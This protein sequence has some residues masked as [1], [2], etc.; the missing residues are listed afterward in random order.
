[1]KNDL[2]QILNELYQIDSSFKKYENELKI[3]IKNILAT[4]PNT[5]FDAS[6]A[7]KLRAELIDKATEIKT[8]NQF[9]VIDLIINSLTMRKLNY[10]AVGAVIAIVIMI[11]VA[12]TLNKSKG[13]FTQT[14][15]TGLQISKVT[16]SAFGS[17]AGGS[18][19]LGSTDG[20]GAAQPRTQSGGGG[21]M[22]TSEVGNLIP[23][24][25]EAINYKYVYKGEPI[26]LDQQTL[27]VLKKVKGNTSA[28]SLT[29]LLQS[30][31]LG[32]ADLSGFSN[33][34]VQN[35]S[36]SQNKPYGYTINANLDEGA[37]T[38][39]KNHKQWPQV[40][41]NDQKCYDQQ[42]I[43]INDLPADD[44]IIKI[45]SDFL[46]AAKISLANYGQPF[47]DNNWKIFY[48]QA[49]DKASFY[50]PDTLMVTYPLEIN[51]QGVFEGNGYPIGLNIAVD[52]KEKKV[53]NV[54]SLTTQNYQSSSY[55]A[56]T[57]ANL[58][59]KWVEKGGIFSYNYGNAQ[60]TLEI[61]VG[62]PSLGYF[63]KWVYQNE[64]N[65]ELLVPAL[66]FPIISRPNIDGVDGRV[67]PNLNKKNVVVPLITEILVE[68]ESEDDGSRIEPLPMP[69]VQID[70]NDVEEVKVE[71]I[72]N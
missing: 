33:S 21:G 24:Y 47:I 53:N 49:T 27:D 55:P 20:I 12:Y 28:D 61:E 58:V 19:Q 43:N 41:C 51:G 57:D 9:S 62:Q 38:I 54:T 52:V 63:R 45:A 17:L 68:F 16:D 7:K 31:N 8:K 30:F 25:Y 2:Q 71:V 3:I 65:D 23:P 50:V 18:E 4:K 15:L 6:F 35:I 26:T 37:L 32:L 39:F 13:E 64:Q 11:P 44:V 59:M 34:Q 48:E 60:D 5:T 69:A 14:F 1:M 29:S 67:V 56:I 40:R 72:Q 10:A 70:I 46:N 42:R 22:P 36:F 66:I